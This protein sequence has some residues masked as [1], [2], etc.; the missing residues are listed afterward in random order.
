MSE[1]RYSEYDVFRKENKYKAIEHKFLLRLKSYY[2]G[3]PT[4]KFCKYCIQVNEVKFLN[5]EH[6]V[7]DNSICYKH[8]TI[9]QY[10]I[11]HFYKSYSLNID[12]DKLINEA[13]YC[14]EKTML[15]LIFANK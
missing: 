11:Y 1:D 5:R 3:K 14:I 2:E 9:L 4:N 13:A 12:F 10:V 7:Q 15:I 6:Q 8:N